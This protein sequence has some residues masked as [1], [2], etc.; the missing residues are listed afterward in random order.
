MLNSNSNVNSL[1]V[2]SHTVFTDFKII[3]FVRVY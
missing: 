1:L 3:N 2:Y